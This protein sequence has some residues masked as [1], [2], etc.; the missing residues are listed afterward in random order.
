VSPDPFD[1]I[2][3]ALASGLSA[4]AP[5]VHGD[6]ETLA[7]L[8][9]RLRRAR[10][11]A[12]VVKISGMIVALAALGAA[13]TLAAPRSTRPHVSVSSQSSVP[14]GPPGRSTTVPTTTIPA[15]SKGAPPGGV[16]SP[17][18][19]NATKT[20]VSPT[21]TVTVP[22]PASGGGPGLSGGGEGRGPDGPPTTTTVAPPSEVQVFR[23]QGG[24]I[25]VRI[26]HDTLTL[27][28]V[29]PASGYATDGTNTSSDSID[30]RFRNGNDK[31]R[32]RV[33]IDD[34]GHLVHEIDAG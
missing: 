5:D 33:Q 22:G 18:T 6:D 24:S 17:T 25:T 27:L 28:A 32:I 19:P 34:Q 3:R 29:S 8:R 13:A 16:T 12:R 14:T 11:R 4:L 7:A 26:S 1:D 2:D 10:T 23:S 31:W 30:V 9:P 15:P 21:T 20:E